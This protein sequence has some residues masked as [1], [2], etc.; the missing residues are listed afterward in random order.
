MAKTMNTYTSVS[1]PRRFLLEIDRQRGDIPRSRFFLR[2]LEKTYDDFGRRDR[3]DEAGNKKN[4][5]NS[6]DLRTGIL[7]S[8]ESV[9]P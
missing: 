2:I 4:Y 5:K 6:V 3:L 7:Q 1:V 9:T 8:T